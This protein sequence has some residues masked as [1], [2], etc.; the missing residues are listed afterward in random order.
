MQP[1]YA[2]AL[3]IRDV[4]RLTEAWRK[5]SSDLEWTSKTEVRLVQQLGAHDIRGQLD[6]VDCRT[7]LCRIKF[8]FA[9]IN[10]ARALYRIE[11]LPG[12]DI[13]PDTVVEHGRAKVTVFVARPGVNVSEITSPPVR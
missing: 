12:Y 9:N 1:T 4:Q 6:E 8:D 3:R 2:R 10:D 13:Y 5:A 7:N 11:R